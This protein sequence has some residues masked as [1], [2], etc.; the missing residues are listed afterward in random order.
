MGSPVLQGPSADARAAGR[1]PNA[2]VPEPHI[3]VGARPPGAPQVHGHE[4]GPTQLD[5]R[6]LFLAHG[7]ADGAQAPGHRSQG[8]HGRHE[9]LGGRPGRHVAEKVSVLGVIV[10]TAV[11][12][13][14]CTPAMCSWGNRE[15]ATSR[16]FKGVG[17]G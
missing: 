15:V 9:R 6:L 1:V 2:G 4:R 12:L 11:I 17:G 8:P 10:F 7:L 3:R 16:V 14:C 5:P 13:G